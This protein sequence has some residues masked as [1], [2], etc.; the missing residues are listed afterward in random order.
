MTIKAT[1]L[2]SI[3]V[4]LSMLFAPSTTLAQSL[5]SSEVELGAYSLPEIRMSKTSNFAV[6]HYVIQSN[7]SIRSTLTR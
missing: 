2:N 1:T 5:W 7:G 6:R 4:T 3:I